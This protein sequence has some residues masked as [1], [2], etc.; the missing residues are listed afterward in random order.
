MSGISDRE[1]RADDQIRLVSVNADDLLKRS[2]MARKVLGADVPAGNPSDPSPAAKGSTSASTSILV[3][4]DDTISAV[5]ST[6]EPSTVSFRVERAVE[7]NQFCRDCSDQ[8]PNSSRSSSSLPAQSA[9]PNDAI[10]SGEMHIEA[11]ICDSVATNQ[12]ASAVHTIPSAVLSQPPCTD[13]T[14]K[15]NTGEQ[16]QLLKN[17]FQLDI[18][19]TVLNNPS[20]LVESDK[21]NTNSVIAAN[22]CCK[23][24]DR[25]LSLPTEQHVSSNEIISEESNDTES[26]SYNSFRT[27]ASEADGNSYQPTESTDA[28]IESEFGRKMGEQSTAAQNSAVLRNDIGKSVSRKHSRIV[29]FT[30]EDFDLFQS[31]CIIYFQHEL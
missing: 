17:N 21:F 31:K 12:P 14:E 23:P 15:N 25:N 19:E 20:Q 1:K 29:S 18:C 16:L 10:K 5:T 8:S 3:A 28:E 6:S 9:V 22:N 24:N 27:M 7:E 11:D 26:K 4:T 2:S 13:V 30:T